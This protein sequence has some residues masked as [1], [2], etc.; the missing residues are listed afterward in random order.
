[1]A[2]VE[3]GDPK[4]VL[5]HFTQIGEFLE[6]RG[7][8]VDTHVHIIDFGY[9]A[10]LLALMQRRVSFSERIK[11]RLAILFLTG[12]VLLPVSV[13]LIHYV[14]L[15]YSPLQS[16]GWASIAADFGGLLVILAIAG[17]LAGVWRH[18]RST[19][20]KPVSDNLRNGWSESALL[21]GG[22]L[23]ILA[24]FLHGAWYAVFYLERHETGDQRL[25]SEIIDRASARRPVV[26]NTTSGVDQSLTAY[27]G[28]QA[29]K[30]INIAAHSHLIEFGIVAILLAFAQELVLLKER[31]KRRWVGFLLAGSAILPVFVLL[32]GRFGLPAGAVADGGGFLIILALSGMLVGVI[33]HGAVVDAATG[34]TE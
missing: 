27:G 7:T 17:E 3:A 28:L 16:I 2:A 6:N 11:L 22:T 13:F 18:F 25:L 24:G 26:E 32:E 21:S 1:T 14:G 15:K 23:L 10:L 31:W 5:A 12:A 19:L 30:A 4:A 34:Y 33:R 20:P 9:L 29:E 8:K